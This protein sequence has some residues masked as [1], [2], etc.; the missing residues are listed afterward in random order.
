[1]ELLS[2]APSLSF[3]R[4]SN[5]IA[6]FAFVAGS[7]SD[8]IQTYPIRVGLCSDYE[9]ATEFNPVEVRKVEPRRYDVTC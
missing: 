9:P 1:M 5:R 3:A 4:L 2:I 6:H 7:V 8:E